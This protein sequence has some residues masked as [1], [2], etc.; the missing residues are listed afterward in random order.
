MKLHPPFKICLLTLQTCSW[1]KNCDNLIKFNDDD[2]NGKE[3][4]GHGHRDDDLMVDLLPSVS[5]LAVPP[6][7]VPSAV[8]P[9]G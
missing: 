9:L 2:S 7:N 1:F 5:E 6:T 3:D 4:D 8:S